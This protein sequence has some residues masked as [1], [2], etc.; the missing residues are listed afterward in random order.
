MKKLHSL[1]LA[2]ALTLPLYLT[3]A[4]SKAPETPED[5]RITA[6]DAEIKEIDAKLAANPTSDES[7]QLRD[8]KMELL[9]EH[10]NIMQ[11]SDANRRN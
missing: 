7:D 6:I 5:A 1:L 11:K 2:L 8:K 10:N 3:P 4:C 9:A